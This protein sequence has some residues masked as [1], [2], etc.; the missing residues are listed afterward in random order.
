VADQRFGYTIHGVTLSANHSNGSL[1][2][3]SNIDSWL[4]WEAPP[5]G[6][7][8]ESVVG[9]L[10][11]FAA[12]NRLAPEQGE[13]TKLRANGEFR[14]AAELL[15]LMGEMDRD[16][17]DDAIPG[18]WIE[19]ASVFVNGNWTAITVVAEALMRLENLFPEEVDYLIH[20]ADGKS[21]AAEDLRMWCTYQFHG[22]SKQREA[23]YRALLSSAGVEA[24]GDPTQG[25]D[26]GNDQPRP[27]S[28]SD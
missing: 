24:G 25:A 26:T 22:Q 28:Q 5:E 15:R 18:R 21:G 27:E 8:E 9:C 11:G 1:D 12:E 3:V 2:R 17:P 10:A 16:D 13:T 4:R 23:R 20:I 19:R 6:V 7:L 14:N